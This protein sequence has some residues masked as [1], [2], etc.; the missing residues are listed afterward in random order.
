VNSSTH[1]IIVGGPAAAAPHFAYAT[2]LN[3]NTISIYAVNATTG[4][5]RA[6]GYLHTSSGH[7][8]SI[9]LDPSGK[10][11]YVTNGLTSDVLHS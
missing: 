6:N 2:N 8:D 5:L 9:C 10:F 3:D 1:I 7:P 11:A 4:Q